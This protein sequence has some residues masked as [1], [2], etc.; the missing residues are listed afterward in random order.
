MDFG[1]KILEFRAKNNLTQMQLSK[2][3]EVTPCMIFRYE[4]GRSKPS[5]K[6]RI[7]FEKKMKEL[8]EKENV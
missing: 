5:A 3:F 7:K 8:E 1:K 6:N 4:A 2:L